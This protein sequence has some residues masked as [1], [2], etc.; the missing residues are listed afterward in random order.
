MGTIL[1]SYQGTL[2]VGESA[3]IGTGVLFV[4]KGK[5]GAHAC[6]GASTTIFNASV[7]PQ[8]VLP[9]GVLTG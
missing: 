5:I 1:H 3:N 7:K 8:Q 2:E 4:G 6:V 9:A